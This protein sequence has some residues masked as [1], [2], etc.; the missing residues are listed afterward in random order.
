MIELKMKN[1]SNEGMIKVKNVSVRV[2]IM[3]VT[4]DEYL[5]WSIAITMGIAS[6][7][8]YIAG[9]K[10]PSYLNWSFVGNLV[11]LM[12]SS[13]N[14]DCELRIFRNSNLILESTLQETCG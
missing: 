10:T 8:V 6:R 13:K 4:K 9:K 14:M 7:D 5:K 12:Q 1:Y 2:T 11:C 3:L